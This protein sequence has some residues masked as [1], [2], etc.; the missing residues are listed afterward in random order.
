MERTLEMLS[1]P[2]VTWL[3]IFLDISIKSIFVLAG[4]AMLSLILRQAS[5]AMRHLV[6]LLAIAGLICLPMLSILLPTWQVPILPRIFPDMLTVQ[7][8]DV[9]SAVAPDQLPPSVEPESW[10]SLRSEPPS[11]PTYFARQ[12]E[13]VGSNQQ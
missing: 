9:R 7:N 4:A 6:W 8:Q 2:S 1:Q 3:T 10:E 12:P 5:A 13:A 11:E